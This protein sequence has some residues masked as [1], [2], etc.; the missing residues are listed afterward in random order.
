MIVW[1]LFNIKKKKRDLESHQ[2]SIVNGEW[3][4]D[5]FY[6]FYKT[7]LYTFIHRPTASDNFIIDLFV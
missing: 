5:F 2:L 7:A 3:L 1:F 6:N 4:K